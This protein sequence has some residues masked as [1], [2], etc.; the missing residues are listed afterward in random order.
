MK[1]KV[2]AKLCGITH[3]KVSHEA[4]L[5]LACWEQ[6]GFNVQ[7]SNKVCVISLCS[8]HLHSFVI[9]FPYHLQPPMHQHVGLNLPAGE[10]P[11]SLQSCLSTL[12]STTI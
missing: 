2:E 7:P 1:N 5:P 9:E 4:G 11:L 3:Q 10:S 12:I 8:Y 6:T